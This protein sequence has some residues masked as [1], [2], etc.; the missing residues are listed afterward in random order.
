MPLEIDDLLS[1]SQPEL[2]TLY[3][4][5][6]AGPDWFEV[7]KCRACGRAYPGPVETRAADTYAAGDVCWN[8]ECALPLELISF[9]EDPVDRLGERILQA[10]TQTTGFLGQVAK[11]SS[12]ELVGFSWGYTIPTDDTPSVRFS[13][14]RDL[15]IGSGVD[16][17]T[18][19]YAAETGVVPKHQ[20]TGVGRTLVE[21]RLE[22]AR[23]AGH[24]RA[25]FRTIDRKRLVALYESLFPAVVELFPDPDPAKS[26]SWYVVDL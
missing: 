17:N 23:R 15:L 24:R 4:Q 18:S 16:P 13:Q 2:I 25:V 1:A 7:A 8:A 11:E 3:A 9:Y 26:Q 19:F 6:F 20:R 12:G 14:V 21:K 10:A 5:V 22:A